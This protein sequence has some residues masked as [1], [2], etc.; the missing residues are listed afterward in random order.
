MLPRLLPDLT[1]LTYEEL[2]DLY[3]QAVAAMRRATPEEATRIERDSVQPL[4]EELTR[5][6]QTGKPP[7]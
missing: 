4:N 6:S 3:V 2:F 1:A 7:H 5:R